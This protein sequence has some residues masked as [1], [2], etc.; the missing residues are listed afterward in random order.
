M[1][2]PQDLKCP[3]SLARLWAQG[4]ILGEHWRSERQGDGKL[5]DGVQLR[6]Y[7][8]KHL[9]S[10]FCGEELGLLGDS[11]KETFPQISS[12]GFT[13]QSGT[14]ERQG[15]FPVGPAS[16]IPSSFSLVPL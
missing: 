4:D 15:A 5:D 8:S 10:L 9:A 12:P 6:S 3:F 16:L 11:S 7:H 14:V 1:T 2:F 13:C